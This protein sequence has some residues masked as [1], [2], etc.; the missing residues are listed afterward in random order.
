MDEIRKEFERKHNILKEHDD[1]TWYD[2]FRSGHQSGR[3][4]VY[5]SLD[6]DTLEL[7]LEDLDLAEQSRE[8]EAL[9]RGDA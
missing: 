4:S 1:G 9:R 2:F 5:A 6:R 7:M 3:D 8:Q